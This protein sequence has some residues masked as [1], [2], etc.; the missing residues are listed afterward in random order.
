MEQ[1]NVLFLLLGPRLKF[2]QNCI[3]RKSKS[4]QQSLPMI[5]LLN[6]EGGQPKTAGH[7]LFPRGYVIKASTDLAYNVY[8][9]FETWLSCLGTK[10]PRP[11]AIERKGVTRGIKAGAVTHTRY[12]FVTVSK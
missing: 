4:I 12:V 2:W 8:C 3:D 1:I 10:N 9:L 7:F 5:P 11:A 6:H